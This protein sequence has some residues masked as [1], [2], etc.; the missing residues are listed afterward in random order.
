MIMEQEKKIKK[1][2]SWRKGDK[3]DTFGWALIVI[4]GA[5]IILADSLGVTDGYTWWNSWGLFFIG[6]GIIGLVGAAL[7]LLVS[8]FPLPSFWD[9]LFAIFFILLGTGN[10]TGWV[11]AVALIVI[12]FSVLR[13]VYQQNR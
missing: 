12:G 5:L 6:I 1:F 8:Q 2:F 7:R 3:G 4:W 10:K 13:N 9:L 11:W